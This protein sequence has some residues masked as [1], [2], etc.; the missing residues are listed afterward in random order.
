M[1]KEKRISTKIWNSFCL[2]EIQDPLS[3][4]GM[5]WWYLD[6]I[7]SCL[8]VILIWDALIHQPDVKFVLD[9]EVNTMR[10]FISRMNCVSHFA[11]LQYDISWFFMW[12]W[13]CSYLDYVE[14]I[15]KITDQ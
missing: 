11:G 6:H 12:L 2:E 15:V 7:P 9:V 1:K 10:S 5:I 13:H 8:H 14:P 3:S 4:L